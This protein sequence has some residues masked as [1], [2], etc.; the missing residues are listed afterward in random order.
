M[1][2]SIHN[3]VK[4]YLS[5]LV[6]SLSPFYSLSPQS[7]LKSNSLTYSFHH[8]FSIPTPLYLLSPKSFLYYVWEGGVGGGEGG[9]ERRKMK[10]GKEASWWNVS[11]LPLLLRL[12]CSLYRLLPPPSTST[13][14]S[15]SS[16]ASFPSLPLTLL[17]PPHRS[18]RLL[19]LAN[20]FYSN[21]LY[22]IG[23]EEM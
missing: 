13:A 5:I 22:L 2:F 21:G 1:N 6:C 11:L 12:S 14:S 23:K 19:L 16:S 18:S 20:A 7:L 17:P 10:E 15:P 4:F 3:I 8:V 9:G